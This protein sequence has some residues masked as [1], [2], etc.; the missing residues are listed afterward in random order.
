MW[1]SRRP[2]ALAAPIA[3]ALL[4]PAAAQVALPPG[5]AIETI[6]GR[7]IVERAPGASGFL[8]GTSG[9]IGGG[10]VSGLSVVTVPPGE[11]F[12]ADP[13][14]QLL[15]SPGVEA[16]YPDVTETLYAMP[17]DPMAGELW[18][19]EAI[20]AVEAWDVRDDASEITVAVID[21]GIFL[22]HEDLKE[23]LW[24]NEGE[25]PGNGVDDD[26][27]GLVDDVHGYDFGDDDGDPNPLERCSGVNGRQ[28][29]P[30]GHGTHVAGT[31]GA[32]GDNATGVVGAAPRVRLMA[33]KVTVGSVENC[34]AASIGAR[35]LALAYAIENGADI[36]NMS[37]GGPVRIPLDRQLLE[38]AA[39]RNVLVVVAAGNSG[40]D[41][42]RE[43]PY[44][45]LHVQGGELRRYAF[46]PEF[47][48]AWNTDTMLAVAASR[49]VNGQGEFIDQWVPGLIWNARVDDVA[50]D[51][52]GVPAPRDGARAV[53]LNEGEVGMGSSFG[54][55]K[56][57][58]GAPGQQILSAAP[59]LSG[60]R[61]TSEY[62][63]TQG[64]SMASPAV[65]GAAAVLWAAFPE[66]NA[67]W[68][69][70]RLIETARRDPSFAD[71]VASGG[72]LDLYAALCGAGA[73]RKLERC[74]DEAQARTNTS[75]PTPT[76]SA[77]AE[78]RGASAPSGN[79]SSVP[80]GAP[81]SDPLGSRN[82]NEVIEW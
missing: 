67:A 64:T 72:H 57:H 59:G 75:V 26:G 10:G 50:Y 29:Q 63:I 11:S 28:M 52:R 5:P 79:S 49:P 54:R 62:A 16:V 19:I 74:A 47:P 58:L 17:N 34:S 68:V 60:G 76:T 69:K 65:A 4:A 39:E 32:V 53:P 56:A 13:V 9:V 3:L 37:L 55:Q 42:D 2:V 36:V 78:D 71:R 23:N 22:E 45:M 43:A 66:Q 27:N 73:P 46:G 35:F 82:L 38:A 25:V 44:A 15:A 12:G 24:V 81:T 1:I 80:S 31:V 7:Y 40:L 41:L 6:P 18:M 77:P 33:L 14:S 20:R 21:S 30:G 51:D 61:F 70:R 48:A 8:P